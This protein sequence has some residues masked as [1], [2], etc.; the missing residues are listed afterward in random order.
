MIEIYQTIRIW[1]AKAL[2][3][4]PTLTA[5][6]RQQLA[7][8]QEHSALS[9][10]YRPTLGARLQ[11]Y[12]YQRNIGSSRDQVRAS[13][14]LDIPLTRSRSQQADR[15]RV[16]AQQI[17]IAN[18]V[19]LAESTIRQEVLALVQQIEHLSLEITAAENELLYREL[20]LDKIRLQYEMEV[21]ARIGGANKD[22]ARAVLRL[23]KA[24]YGRALAWE[25][26]YAITMP[27]AS[28]NL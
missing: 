1:S 19:L 18:Q 7:L 8:Q 10:G 3:N 5:L 2:N 24:K 21:R 4:H 6:R 12:E 11:A 28:T 15:A 25:K 17:Q 23:I 16:A 20:E 14:Y 27:V 13:L 9:F 22:V 26:L